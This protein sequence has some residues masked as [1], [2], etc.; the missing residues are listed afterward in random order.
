MAPLTT[1]A[2]TLEL[3]HDTLLTLDAIGTG[4]TALALEASAHPE[5]SPRVRVLLEGF[6]AL[7]QDCEDDLGIYAALD[8]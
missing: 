7:L 5:K 4:V 1:S 2:I 6:Q 3:L 8:S